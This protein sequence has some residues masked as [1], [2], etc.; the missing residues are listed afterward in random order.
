MEYIGSR[1]QCPSQAGKQVWFYLFSK[2][3]ENLFC[4]ELRHF[5]KMNI[6]SIEGHLLPF[7]DQIQ[8]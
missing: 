6:N 1:G 4:R 3:F 7:N 2:F 5:Y 8:K